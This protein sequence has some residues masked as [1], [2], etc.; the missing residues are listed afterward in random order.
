MVARGSKPGKVTALCPS[1]CMYSALAAEVLSWILLL[2]LMTELQ[3]LHFHRQAV[4]NT[5]SKACTGR[6]CKGDSA[7]RTAKTKGMFHMDAL[8]G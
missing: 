4:P 6:S 7:M 3:R 8:L 5:S 1:D 2:V